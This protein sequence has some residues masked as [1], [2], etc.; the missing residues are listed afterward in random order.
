M[1]QRQEI[2]CHA[3]N[4]WVQFEIDLELDGNHVLR[5]PNCDHEHC[6]VVKKGEIT[7]IRWDRRNGPTITIQY[8][9]YTQTAFYISTCV[10]TNQTSYIG[11][12]LSDLWM[13]TGSS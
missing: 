1:K 10:Q 9:T 7:D 2:H 4:K 8:A 13:T 12:Y 11:S 5:C 3:C 6:R